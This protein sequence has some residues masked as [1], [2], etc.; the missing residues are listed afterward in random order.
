MKVTI[1]IPVYN[2]EQYIVRCLDSVASQ[3]YEG[4]IE[5]LLVDDCGPD[6][7]IQICRDYVESY[8]GLIEFKIIQR[9]QNGGL[10]AARNTGLKVATGDYIYFLDSDD[11]LPSNSI[12]LLVSEVSKHPGIDVVMGFMYD[13]KHSEYYNL[14][15]F[16]DHQYTTDRH[17]LQFYTYNSEKV[18]PA[19]GCNKLLRKLFLLDN[20]LLFKPGIIH[21]D[22]HWMFFLV[23]NV[24]SW[25]FV[26][27]PTYIRYW[28]EG[29]IMT[30]RNREKEAKNWIEIM[31]D[32][33]HNLYAPFT[34]LQL[35]KCLYLYFAMDFFE[36]PSVQSNVLCRQFIQ[37]CL[38]ERL[39]RF[40]FVMIIWRVLRSFGHG[41]R[42]QNKLKHYSYCLFTQETQRNKT[43]WV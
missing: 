15:C 30:S 26:F 42:F 33:C 43:L 38:R 35:A 8:S 11:E 36:F 41:T 28:N 25:S 13:D 39:Y 17:W 2:V 10:S 12:E 27:E 20:N 4:Q 16:K 24:K 18:I 23:K 19:N 40:V 1:I 34:K 37:K 31:N 14:N 5:C 6:N 29:S 9:E 7:S 22:E 3:T 32:F 21:E